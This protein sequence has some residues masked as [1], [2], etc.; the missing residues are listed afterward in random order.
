MS[1]RALAEIKA[2]VLQGD[3]P[4]DWV[5]LAERLI[6]DKILTSFQARRLL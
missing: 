3:Y 5:E 1:D 4:L 2:K 6:R